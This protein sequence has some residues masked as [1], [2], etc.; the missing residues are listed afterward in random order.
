[1]LWGAFIQILW[2]ISRKRLSNAFRRIGRAGARVHRSG[3]LLGRIGRAGR[4]GHRSGGV[5]EAHRLGSL[6][7]ALNKKR[8]FSRAK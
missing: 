5:F 2:Q 7:A 4:S 8:L 3:S 1:M 6:L